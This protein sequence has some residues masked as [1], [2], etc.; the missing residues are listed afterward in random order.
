MAR[1]HLK[2]NP[3]PHDLPYDEWIPTHAV[4]FND[5]GTVSLMTEI[6]EH[7]RG[8]R[9]N[10]KPN[11]IDLINTYNEASDPGAYRTDEEHAIERERAKKALREIR[12]HYIEGVD[13]RELSNGALWPIT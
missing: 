10:A 9:R 7:N 8:R 11:L 3:G 6:P 4:R 5:D 1:T 12:Q 2:R 13:Y